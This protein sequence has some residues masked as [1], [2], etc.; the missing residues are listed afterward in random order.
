MRT[1]IP[2]SSLLLFSLALAYGQTGAK[3]PTFDVASVK[4]AAPPTPDGRGM[5]RIGGPSGGPGTSD[6]GRVHYPYMTLK[7][8]M[9]TAYE[10][11]NFQVTGPAWLDTERFEISATMPPDTTKEQ[12]HLMLQNLLAE[13]FKLTLHRE[14]KELPMYSLVVTKNGPKMKESAAAPPPKEGDQPGPAPLPERPTMGADG[15]PVIP[16]GGRAGIFNI[17]MNGRARM[18]AQQQTMKDLADR[19]TGQVN[20]PVK[21]ETGL[22]AKYDFTITYEPDMGGRGP[23]PG[24]PGPAGGAMIAVA[25]PGGGAGGGGG[26]GV[27]GAVPASDDPLPNLFAAIQSQ[28]GL[29]LESKKGPVELIVI[30]HVEKTPTEN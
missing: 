16:L 17:M 9:T 24:M 7:N 11:K 6:P 5:I 22:A 28:L 8:L 1:A 19:L 13:R 21:D 2:R 27:G 10:V 20:R 12:F 29:K 18:I 30:D 4:V 23:M 26:G 14:T 3:S 15:F 25:P